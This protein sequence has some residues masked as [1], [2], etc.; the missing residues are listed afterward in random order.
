MK[1]KIV[2]VLLFMAF[3]I[4]HKYESVQEP[5]HSFM[6]SD[7]KTY[8]WNYRQRVTIPAGTEVNVLRCFKAEKVCKIQWGLYLYNPPPYLSFV[9]MRTIYYPFDW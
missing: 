4:P 3:I 8:E 1:T 7:V 9:P 6:I 5:Y 2:L